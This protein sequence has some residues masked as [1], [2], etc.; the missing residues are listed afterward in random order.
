M[1]TEEDGKLAPHPVA[2]INNTGI[3]RWTTR[4]ADT[5]NSSSQAQKKTRRKEQAI[6][7]IKAGQLPME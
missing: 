7:F 6:K 4:G 2:Q 5:T 1:P 3:K